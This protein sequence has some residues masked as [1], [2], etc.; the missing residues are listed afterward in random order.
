MPREFVGID[1]DRLRQLLESDTIVERVNDDKIKVISRE[2]DD[3][4]LDFLSDI[5]AFD[6]WDASS[7]G[8]EKVEFVLHLLDS[9]QWKYECPHCGKGYNTKL[10]YDIHVAGCEEKGEEEVEAVEVSLAYEEVKGAS[11][12]DLDHTGE[13]EKQETEIDTSEDREEE[14]EKETVECQFCGEEVEKGKLGNHHAHCEERFEQI[15]EDVEEPTPVEE[16]ECP[17]CG[18]DD[19]EHVGSTVKVV[20]SC[21]ECDYENDYVDPEQFEAKY[22]EEE[23]TDTSEEST[24]EPDTEKS[25]GENLP[26]SPQD[27]SEDTTE[28]AEEEDDKYTSVCDECGLEFTSNDIDEVDRL[29]DE[30]YEEEHGDEEEEFTPDLPYS[31]EDFKKKFDYKQNAQAIETALETLGQPATFEEIGKAVLDIDQFF[32]RHRSY[33]KKIV[34]EEMNVVYG[35]LVPADG[36]GR[37]PDLIA[38]E[39]WGYEEGFTVVEDED[40]ELQEVDEEEEDTEQEE[41]E[42]SDSSTEETEETSDSSTDSDE[43][44]EEE[45]EELG[46]D[47]EEVKDMSLEKRENFVLG[48]FEAGEEF[49]SSDVQE[50]FWGEVPETGSTEYNIAYQTLNRLKER[51]EVEKI[52]RGVYRKTT[53]DFPSYIPRGASPVQLEGWRQDDFHDI[54]DLHASEIVLRHLADGPK[55]PE[56]IGKAIM[57]EQD[58]YYKVIRLLTEYLEDIVHQSNNELDEETY[59]L[60]KEVRKRIEED[61]ATLPQCLESIENGHYVCLDCPDDTAYKG[62]EAKKH[63]VKEGHVNWKVGSQ[64]PIEWQNNNL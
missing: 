3:E 12:E 53:D 25:S 57:G 2:F 41:E 51:D 6:S 28:D 56:E 27:S 5:Y 52:R 19:I 11:P 59:Y 63:R 55:T 24:L 62:D 17:E 38:L 13:V 40:G 7:Y 1:K 49:E 58:G 46:L 39:R 16:L 37:K 60:E 20:Y 54:P 47:V 4:L 22:G 44:E 48:E 8:E 26:P 32:Q 36:G 9:D 29:L 23:E 14:E 43:Q 34:D 10:N 33:V 61:E 30:H 64:M 31:Y 15:L 42:S 50:A 18:S 45:R 35:R 21:N